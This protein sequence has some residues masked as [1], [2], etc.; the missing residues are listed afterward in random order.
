MCADCL[1]F[2]HIRCFPSFVLSFSSTC[3]LRLSSLFSQC[4]FCLAIIPCVFLNILL[5]AFLF[6][7]VFR[8]VLLFLDFSCISIASNKSIYIFVDYP[9][10]SSADGRSVGWAH[11][12]ASHLAPLNN[13][14]L[15][16]CFSLTLYYILL[17]STI[18][19]HHYQHHFRF[20]ISFNFYLMCI[21][22]S[23]NWAKQTFV[24]APGKHTGIDQKKNNEE[25]ETFIRIVSRVFLLIF[26]LAA[27]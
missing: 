7:G 15:S 21:L 18:Q 2:H 13:L 6:C 25:N 14:T 5:C 22:L 20:N 17:T 24:R 23:N 1:Y 16:L 11:R 19:H 26:F 27:S 8:S 3:L 10:I 9:V 4:F 12:I